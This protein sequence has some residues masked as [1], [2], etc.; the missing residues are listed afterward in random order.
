MN[1][2][3][4]ADDDETILAASMR[5]ILQDMADGRER[6]TDS[7]VVVLLSEERA[8]EHDG[9][10]LPIFHESGAC[11]R[12]GVRAVNAC[13]AEWVS[14][15]NLHFAPAEDSRL[16]LDEFV[17]GKV[18]LY[19]AG[20]NSW[21]S[22]TIMT[23]CF[24]QI[25]RFSEHFLDVFE[26]SEHI[27]VPSGSCTSMVRVFYRDLLARQPQLSKRSAQLSERVYEFSEFVVNVLG[28]ENVGPG[29]AGLYGLPI[30]RSRLGIM[31]HSV[32]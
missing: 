26:S 24:W 22:P 7:Q 8:C 2:A 17:L 3:T 6:I 28:Y 25:A 1:C 11:E 13:D 21:C 14:L 27:V 9:D 32:R 23:R 30:V 29:C 10:L 12:N 15:H 19:Y 16:D 5:R 20:V 18:S 31:A 4:S